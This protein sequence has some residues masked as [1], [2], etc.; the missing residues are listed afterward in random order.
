MSDS[1]QKSIPPEQ[2]LALDLAYQQTI[3]EVFSGSQVIHLQVNVK[4][5]QLD[6]LLSQHQ[7]NSWA[8]ITAHNPFSQ[9]LAADENKRRNQSL[10]LALEQRKFS[11]LAGLGRDADGHWPPE[12][13]YFVLGI[14]QEEAMEVGR[15][16]CQN[17]LLYG[18]QQQAPELVWLVN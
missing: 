10:S 18:E 5:P 13:S 6:R 3:Y 2:F 15:L 8:L 4:N 14:S 7:E 9:L 11:A 17:A 12:A 16:F 1:N